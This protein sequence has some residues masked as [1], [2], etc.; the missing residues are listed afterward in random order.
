MTYRLLCDFD[1]TV[2][3]C[4]VTDLLLEAFAEPGW[5]AIEERWQAGEIG[6][7]ACMA[8]QVALMRAGRAA[9]DALL[10]SVRIDPAFPDFVAFCREEGLPLAIVS[11]GLDYAIARILAAN[12]ITGVPIL[13]NHLDFRP[14]NRF[15]MSSPRAA[16]DCGAGAGTCKCAIAQENALTGQ[17]VV[18]IGD[19]RSD[20]CV[21]NRVDFVF[22]K[23]RLVEYCGENGIPHHAF[24]GFAE[25][26]PVLLRL[27]AMP[28][29]RLDEALATGQG[30]R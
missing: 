6:S 15:A 17:P 25:V 27:L 18:L 24:E 22:A 26:A 11:D 1:G 23:D 12:G 10:D 7:A 21:S 20:F 29:P 28:V 16:A 4:D 8:Q 9:L 19:G 2:S 3:L 14:G 30:E 13:A 5:Q